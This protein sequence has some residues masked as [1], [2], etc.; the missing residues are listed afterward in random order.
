MQRD[1]MQ[2]FARVLK[3]VSV[4]TIHRVSLGETARIVDGFAY[5]GRNISFLDLT[6]SSP[7]GTFKD[8]I[9]CVT[10]AYCLENRVSHLITQTSGNTGNAIAAYATKNSVRATILYPK[11]SRYKIDADLTVSPC[12]TF[13]EIDDRQT[14]IK[15]YTN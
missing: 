13:F 2:E 5:K 9:A 12:P 6:S 8:W 11:S 10:I 14:V 15:D 1:V 3:G 7:T 4:A